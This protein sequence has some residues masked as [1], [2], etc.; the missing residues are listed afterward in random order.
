[1]FGSINSYFQNKSKKE[2]LFISFLTV[3]LLGSI[4]FITGYELSFSVFYLAPVSLSVWYVDK[5]SGI[6][7]SFFSAAVWLVVD[8]ASGH[9]YSRQIILFW[10]A[11][12]RLGFFLVTTH[13][14]ITV[15]SH[16]L[17]EELLSR[18]DSLTGLMN[19]RAF[20]ENYN[21]IALMAKR[22][23]HPMA[24]GYLDLDNFKMV[25][26]SLGH[27]A[28][29][30]LLQY[31][32]EVLTSSVRGTDFT[33][34]MGGDEFALLLPE[35]SYEGAERLFDKIHRK[36]NVDSGHIEIPVSFSIGVS[37]FRHDIPEYDDALKEVDSLMYEVKRSG[38]NNIILKEYNGGNKS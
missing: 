19:E 18:S 20:K 14:L 8:H 7:L 4:D 11:L 24:L 2:N 36:L 28:G 26:D 33:A 1:M 32:A 16:I 15:K 30:R 27:S 17:N 38:K 31:V 12:V 25:N 21:R 22:Y 13:L 10:N 3:I 37:I 23:N 9:L 29:N 5:N 35:T 6:F 34:R